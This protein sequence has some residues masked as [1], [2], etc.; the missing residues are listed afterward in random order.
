MARFR[1]RLTYANVVATLAL[2]LVV[3][4]GSA[5]AAGK[6]AKGS[7][8][9]RQLKAGAVTAAKIKNGAVTGAK[10]AN[11]TITGK[12]VNEATLG[13]V[14]DA[15]TL[16]GI[17]SSAFTRE[18]HAV[19][20]QGFPVRKSGGTA[21][22]VNITAPQAGYLLAIGSGTAIGGPGSNYIYI[23]GFT[24]DGIPK[25]ESWRF[26]TISAGQRDACGSNAIVPVSAGKHNVK[27]NFFTGLVEGELG[28]EFSELDVVFIPL[29]G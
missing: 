5:I 28:T 7:V 29:S 15:K 11:D 1:P 13:Q 9:S 19:S 6:L 26:A 16:D 10:V 25:E 18:A 20:D 23:C 22:E 17:G 21:D 3:A 24:F 2:F 27:L 8:G 12:N 14:P 4:G